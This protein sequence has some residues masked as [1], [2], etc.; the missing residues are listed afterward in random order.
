MS[1]VVGRRLDLDLALLWLWC[2]ST[3]VAPIQPL[4]WEPPCAVGVALRRQ[5][6]VIS[7]VDSIHTNLLIVLAWHSYTVSYRWEKLGKRYTGS[8]CVISF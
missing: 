6:K 3:A 5:K 7:S 4:A 1:H 2:R 8:L